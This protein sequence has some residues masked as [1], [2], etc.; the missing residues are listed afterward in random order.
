I[1][2]G[3][4]R[5]P[6]RR[7]GIE[8]HTLR[9]EQLVAAVPSNH[10]IAKRDSVRLIDLRDE[11]FVTYPSDHRSVVYDAVLDACQHAGFCPI[12]VH[13]VR[14]TSTLLS[15]VAADLGVALL[16]SSAQQAHVRGVDFLQLDDNTPPIELAMATRSGPEPQHIG[17][18]REHI[19]QLCGPVD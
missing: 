14:E 5:P 10:A 19:E 11:A 2:V 9:R 4:L 13:E 17:W 7:P 8:V 15:F 1:D 18:I 3:L 16:P 6:V 12:E